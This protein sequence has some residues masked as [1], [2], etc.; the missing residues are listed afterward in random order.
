MRRGVDA[1]R[2]I[3]PVALR[4][5]GAG[6]IG[7]TIGIAVKRAGSQLAL[8][9]LAMPQV[10]IPHVVTPARPAMP[11][12]ALQDLL[13]DAWEAVRAAG[14]L[15]VWE[16][17]RRIAASPTAPIVALVASSLMLALVAASLWRRDRQ[18]DA[19]DAVDAVD[20]APAS[21][22]VPR[23]MPAAVTA[24]SRRLLQERTRASRTRRGSRAPRDARTPAMVPTLAATGADRTEIARR[25]GLSRDAVALS[26]NLTAR[27]G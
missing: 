3:M 14:E 24:L 5:A 23:A 10:A 6:V 2:A 26:L 8:P 19:G 16:T 9:P 4:I 7:A 12:L 1:V 11:Q 15:P 25:T 18:E 17:A 22:F 13:L 21:S 20:A 27:Q